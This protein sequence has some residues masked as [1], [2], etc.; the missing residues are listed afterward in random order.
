MGIECGERDAD[1]G[2]IGLLCSGLTELMKVNSLCMAHD[3]PL[4]PHGSGPYSYH[5]SN[6]SPSLVR[7]A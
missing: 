5:V 3:I 7:H 4:V 6:E 1:N 2:V